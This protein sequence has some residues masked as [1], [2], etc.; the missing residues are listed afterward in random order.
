[1]ISMG[2]DELRPAVM[3]ASEIESQHPSTSQDNRFV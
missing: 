2:M 1:V 3:Q